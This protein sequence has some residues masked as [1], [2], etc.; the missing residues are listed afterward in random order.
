MVRYTSPVRMWRFGGLSGASALALFAAACTPDDPNGT[1]N[2][3]DET[4][5]PTPK[6]ECVQ[7]ESLCNGEV[8]W[9]FQNCGLPRP[10]S[11]LHGDK[12][13]AEC[14]LGLLVNQ[15]QPSRFEYEI[16]AGNTDYVGVF[17][18]L[19][20]GMGLDTSCEFVSGFVN[21]EIPVADEFTLEPPEYFADCIG[22]A[23]HVMTGCI[24]NG[25]HRAGKPAMCR[26]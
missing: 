25:M 10:C 22:K 1:S 21:D 13:A 26:D 4:G 8:Y 24:F 6:C 9:A 19:G 3:E 20:T 18:I 11:T 23:S 15:D 16:E 2:D 14:V 12:D 5:Q 7:E 17:Y